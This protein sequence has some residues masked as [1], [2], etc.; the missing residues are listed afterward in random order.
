MEYVTIFP[1]THFMTNKEKLEESIKRI[2]SELDERVAYFNNQN[3]LLETERIK[4]RTNYDLEMLEEIGTC[5]GVENYSRHMSLREEGETPATLIDFFGDDFLMIIDESHVTLPQVRGMYNGD[6]SRKQNLVDYGFRLPSALD[7]RP[8]M[9]EE[10]EKKLDKVIYLSA[11][12][13]DYELNLGYPLVEQI[14]RPTYLLDPVIEIRNPYGQ[15]DD[16]YNEIKQ[17]IEKNQRV[18]ITTLTIRMSED[19]TDYLKGLGLKVTYLHSEIK[20]LERIEILR[21]LRLGVYDV[22]V[23]INLLREGLDLPEVSLVIILDADKT[24]F[25][26]SDTALIQTIGRAARHV[27]GKAIMYAD[28]IS[29][30]MRAA[31]DETNRR[32]EKQIAYNKAHG[33]EPVSIVKAIHDLTERVRVEAR[34]AISPTEA[35]EGLPSDE[36]ERIIYELEAQMKQAAANLEFEKAALLRDQIFELRELLVLQTTGRRD[37][38]IWEQDR[39]MPIADIPDEAP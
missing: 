28:T 20:A 9:F 1:A 33:I 11:T 17:R 6:R 29:D 2:K 34:E 39:V 36:L 5:S 27:N 18:L 4:L 25:L 19:L 38:P 35:V 22:V 23:G 12:P 26:R 24:G 37:V 7:N 8:L 15:M 10:F 30:A 14:I 21:N 32:R 3:K 16:I 13:G 31:I